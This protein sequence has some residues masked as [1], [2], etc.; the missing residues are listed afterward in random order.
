MKLRVKV[1]LIIGLIIISLIVGLYA[2][3]S[4]LTLSGYGRLEDESILQDIIRVTKA[5]SNELDQL[6]AITGDWANWNE[7]YSF[8]RDHNQDFIDD[9]LKDA[10]MATIGVNL[11]VILDTSGQIVFEKA[12][13]IDTS[14]HQLP[15][16]H[17]LE[18]YIS[19]QSPLLSPPEPGQGRTGFLLLLEGPM[20][21]SARPILNSNWEGPSTGTLIFG[22][23]LDA[24]VIN[25]LLT[26]TGT[27]LTVTRYDAEQM[28][29][30]IRTSLA[31][32][33]QGQEIV[34]HDL[35]LDTIAAYTLVKDIYGNP[36][37]VLRVHANRDI[38]NQ[39]KLM[40]DYV[41][42]ALALVG[43]VFGVVTMAG[44]ER[45]VLNPLA[46][47]THEVTQI[48]DT[49][50]F[51]GRVSVTGTDEI[52][53]LAGKTNQMLTRI[54]EG[55]ERFRQLVTQAHEGILS[56]DLQGCISF[57]NP[58]MEK[59]LG[60]PVEELLGK[61]FLSLMD[62]NNTSIATQILERCKQ[63]I[64]ERY[65]LTFL[66]KEGHP[67]ITN[68]SATP[69]KDE[70]GNIQGSFA[71][72]ED[73]TERMQAITETKRTLSLLQSSLE[74]TADGLLIV[75]LAGNVVLFNQR[76]A[77]M[78]QIPQDILETGD[79]T[80]LLAYITNQLKDPQ[81]FIQK[82]QELYAQTEV[83]SYDLLEFKD[84]RVFERFSTP[85]HLQGKAV[86]RVWSFRD[87]TER[88][89]SEAALLE[90]EERYRTLIENQGEGSAF[91]DAEENIVFANL[92]AENLFGV[93]SGSL[94]GRN[95]KEFL[96]P[97]QIAV[98]L[99][100][101][102]KRRTGEKS[103]YEL[104][105]SRPD[106][107]QRSVLITATPQFNPE[108][109]F[110]GA[111][112]IFRD[113]TERV[114]AEEALRKQ[115]Q[116]LQIILDSVPSNIWYKDKDNKYL[117]V[118]KAVATMMNMSVEE[119][120]G[121]SPYDL[122]PDEADRIYTDDM[123]VINTGRPK[124][125]IIERLHLPGGEIKW[126]QTDKVPYRDE[127]GNITG[128][129]I[130]DVDITERKRAEE[131]LRESEVRFRTLIEEASIAISIARDGKIIYNNP[132]Y[133]QMFGYQNAEELNGRFSSDLYTPQ[134]RK[135]IKEIIR[136][137]AQGKP[138]PNE[139]EVIGQ[140][141]DG[142][143]FNVHVSVA[144]VELADGPANI[145]FLTD[146][147]ERKRVENLRTSLYG[148]SE[149]AHNVHNLDALFRSL[150]AIVGELLPA[151][152]FFISLYD[153]ISDTVSYPYFVDEYDPE[154]PPQRKFGRG[155]TE[156]VLRT[157]EPLLASPEV[158]GELV[159][160]GDIESIGATSL[161]W[162]GVPLKT[163]DKVIGVLAVQ[164]YT[165]GVR[166]NEAHKDILL[167]VSS[168]IAMAIERVAAEEALRLSTERLRK[169]MD[170]ADEIFILLDS[171]L[172][173]MDF[174]L[175]AEKHF[176]FV[177]EK[178]IGKNLLEHAPSIKETGQYDELLD[179][180]RTGKPVAYNDLLIP[181]MFGDRVIAIDAFAV[182]DGLGVIM[183]DITEQKMAELRLQYMATHD[184][185]TGLPNRA[186]FQDRLDHAISLARRNN[187]KVAVMFV[188][189]D[190]FKT[191][192][193]NHG[194]ATGDLLLTAISERLVTYLRKSD[195]VSRLG[196]DE[197][198]V[199][200]E[201]FADEDK[202]AALAEKILEGISKPFW[203]D[204]EEIKVTAS[205]GISYYPKDDDNSEGLLQK[206]DAAMYR[207]K[208]R[209]NNNYQFY[210]E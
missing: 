58:S 197:Y 49:Q 203:I 20:L 78:W 206:A 106:G 194:H 164:S 83:E 157:G 31:A 152:N 27:S 87:I 98:V 151:N 108:Q 155:L 90:S 125:G 178:D 109:V 8:A 201:N 32:L 67:V 57:A 167:F 107:E 68:L 171:K 116:E 135:E 182:G 14:I 43:L 111:W 184:S 162:L 163:Q 72:I 45:F 38:Y 93:P 100:Q 33:T 95:T 42:L 145:G 2:V 12:L 79:D 81:A 51:S 40:L 150:H 134:S 205:I 65:D 204:E 62:Q 54:L 165:E 148:I 103:T 128:T 126:F 23:F 50:D 91:V 82:V 156:Y 176:G 133:A 17:G 36:A 41:L 84:G 24:P 76:F 104:E 60:Y 127:H 94:V 3:L 174:N 52:S 207:S 179:V 120:K 195:T 35:N 34:I 166:F 26:D 209:S 137:R 149:L 141:K 160:K 61:T 19:A 25:R 75:D 183:R 74:S 56:I 124:L 118:N 9:N 190:N 114:K 208:Q 159:A 210:S 132:K 99:A 202:L 77:Q 199:L 170:S 59:V 13:D 142:T 186:L 131:A 10:D 168:Q 18:S 200:V 96:T 139:Y 153:P 177:K 187:E 16:P 115:Q 92:A 85:Q 110:L 136:R 48:G 69:V 4:W 198:T 119:I 130:F 161:D 143:R 185:L 39:G 192:N 173:I 55:E 30:D 15:L 22:R 147:T 129:I 121:K 158:F 138:V 122:F 44:M 193:D 112:A 97:D 70:S 191:V 169:F 11:V 140:R 21:V 5:L 146:I 47:L 71:I 86:G 37:A 123:E 7:T 196:G 64:S 154:P 1:G 101:T 80:K 180:I 144:N 6:N 89:R 189:L 66:H 102:A 28:T 172:N 73:T 105:I 188:D 53:E 175:S 117:R 181:Q 63:G 46:R 88:T 29:D 113:I